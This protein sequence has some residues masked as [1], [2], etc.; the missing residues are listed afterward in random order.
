MRKVTSL[1]RPLRFIRRES[2]DFTPRLVLELVKSRRANGLTT[3]NILVNR[4][5]APPIFYKSNNYNVT[6]RRLTPHAAVLDIP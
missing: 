2:R 3:R 1:I 4:L 6:I 5:T